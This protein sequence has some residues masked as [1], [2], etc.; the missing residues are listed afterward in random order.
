MEYDCKH[1]P[2]SFKVD[3]DTG[4]FMDPR[5]EVEFNNWAKQ[6]VVEYSENN[7]FNPLEM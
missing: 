3:Y 4:E 2:I 5:A 1:W 7:N 6:S